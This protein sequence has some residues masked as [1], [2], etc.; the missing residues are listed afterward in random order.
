MNEPSAIKATFADFKIVKTRKL[1]QLIFEIPIEQADSALAA[2]GGIPRSDAERWVAIALLVQ[3]TLRETVDELRAVT[4]KHGVRLSADRDGLYDEAWQDA[5]Y[6]KGEHAVVDEMQ[7]GKVGELNAA[8]LV[9]EETRHYVP[10]V[11]ARREFCDLPF[12]QQ[13]AMR[14]DDAKFA[15]WL[16]AGP[17]EDCAKVI[18]KVCGVASR[19]KIIKGSFAGDLWVELL[20]DYENHNAP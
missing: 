5:A 16:G 19:T 2:L 6:H 17:G 12:P 8:L 9:A 15:A 10:T 20:R 13:A 3:Q 18:R 11:K 1:A 4:K 14:S 7:E